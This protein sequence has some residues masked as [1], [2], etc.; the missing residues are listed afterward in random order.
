VGIEVLDDGIG[1]QDGQEDDDLRPHQGLS[2]VESRVRLLDG[3]FE[4]VS[5]PGAG[6]SV[7][8]EVPA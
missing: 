7:R 3:R 4:V 8:V 2:I 6:A 1:F 5:T